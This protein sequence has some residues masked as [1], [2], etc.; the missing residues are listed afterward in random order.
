[1]AETFSA[2]PSGMDSAFAFSAC[3]TTGRGRGHGNGRCWQA[4]S[5]T[6]RNRSTRTSCPHARSLQTMVSCTGQ[7]CT[8]SLH[9]SGAAPSEEREEEM[10]YLCTCIACLSIMQI[11]RNRDLSCCYRELRQKRAHCLLCVPSTLSYL[12]ALLLVHCLC[13]INLCPPA[14]CHLIVISPG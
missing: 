6:R 1:M 12:T 9:S 7:T 10:I 3:P 5:H 13:I 2:Q 11:Y 14:L 4:R 8:G